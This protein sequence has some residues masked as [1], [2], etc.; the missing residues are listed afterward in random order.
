MDVSENG[1]TNK[2]TEESDRDDSKAEEP[3]KEEEEEE[4]DEEEEEPPCIK[5]NYFMLFHVVSC[6]GL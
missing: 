4:E 5:D 6:D 1:D 3:V 2:A